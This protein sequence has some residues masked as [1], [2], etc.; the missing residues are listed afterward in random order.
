RLMKTQTMLGAAR[1][2]ARS[3]LNQQA[4]PMLKDFLRR[5]APGVGADDVRPGR[6][7]RL[8]GLRTFATLAFAEEL[9]DEPDL[10]ESYCTVFEPHDDATL[11]ISTPQEADA[12][13]R[14]KRTLADLPVPA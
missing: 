4:R 8:E 2:L 3:L 1:T 10:L 6:T 14:V 7:R 13:A 11:V 5:H 9:V 12:I